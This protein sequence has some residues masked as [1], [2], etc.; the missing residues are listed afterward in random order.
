MPGASVNMPYVSV[1]IC[2]PGVQDANQCVTIDHMLLDT[3]SAGVRVMASALGSALAGRLPAQ[4]GAS[5]DP[6]GGAPIAQCTTFGAGYTWG[7]IKR[8]D[9][10]IGGKTAG[11]LPIQVIG[12]AAYPNVPSDCASRGISNIGS[13]VAA[14]G[15]NGVV[16]I[17]P[18]RTDYPAAAQSA[19]SATYYY[20]PSTGSCTGARVPLDTQV[21]N[22]VANFT[23]D[24][25]GTIVRLPALPAGGQATAT[26][27]LIFGIGTRQNNALPPTANVLKVD[28]SGAFTTVYQGRTLTSYVDSGTPILWFP[29]TTT[30]L[31][32]DDFYVPPTTLDLSA[33]WYSVDYSATR[34]TGTVL[35]VPFSI[36]NSS[37]LLASQYAA[38][39]NLGRFWSEWTFLWGLPFFYGR[40]LYTALSNAKVGAQTG[41]FIAF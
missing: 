22:P 16:G 34:K 38:Y 40:D 25:N 17:S 21:M 27:E 26:G 28:N 8:A 33:T 2:I 7:S 3:G 15:A 24:N 12:D 35:T 14:L 20:C 6:T 5:N 29:D 39:G 23:S 36:A 19:L 10:T 4:T 31:R 30:P 37:N 9:V 18:S 41:P 13:T 1:A 11:N 32:W